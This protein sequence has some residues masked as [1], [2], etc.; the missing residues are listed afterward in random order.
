MKTQFSGKNSFWVIVLVLL[1]GAWVVGCSSGNVLIDNLSEPLNG[2]STAKVD[3]NS[4][5]GH[6]TIDKLASGDQL[7]AAG[8]LQYLERQG[9]PAHTVSMSNSEATL[10]LKAGDSSQSGFRFPWTVCGGSY[11]WRINL[12]PAVPSDI[13]AHS[14]GGNVK[15][16]LVGMAVSHL[17]ADSEG[18]NID[19][20]LPDNTANLVTTAKT[21]GGNINIEFGSGI[22]GNN[23]VTASSGAG[24]VVVRLPNGIA[25]KV[26]A[27]T[28]LGKVSVDPQFSR[29]DESTY[30]SAGYDTA[31]N[32]I[33]ITIESGAGNVSVITK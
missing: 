29:I 4:S 22:V 30:K 1:L 17:A 25:A 19:V 23:I 28:G 7:L 27:T 14:D 2:A 16:N 20:V 15:L 26:Y 18:G 5:I 24:N 21:G 9:V 8:T 13:S 3:I 33:E 12:N 31:A 32:K 10:T 11:E 6:L